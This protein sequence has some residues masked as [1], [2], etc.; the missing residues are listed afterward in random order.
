M[1]APLIQTEQRLLPKLIDIIITAFAWCG[2]IY[3]FVNGL[4]ATVHHAPHAG[5]IPLHIYLLEGLSTIVIYLL[6]ALFNALV[7]IAWAKYNQVRWRVER[8]QHRP[9][10]EDHELASTLSVQAE[11]IAEL[12]GG[13]NFVLYNDE[14][15]RLVDVKLGNRH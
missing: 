8:R 1:S 9:H 10:L 12:K 13:N 4:L 7:L 6:I 3:L 14:D 5:T 2:F 15:G 11:L